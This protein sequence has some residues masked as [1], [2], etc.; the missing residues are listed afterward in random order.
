MKKYYAYEK[1]PGNKILWEMLPGNFSYNF[2]TYS[3]ILLP[4]NFFYAALL[5]GNFIYTFDL[6]FVTG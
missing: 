6:D 3:I 5:P 1:L 4:G 2:L